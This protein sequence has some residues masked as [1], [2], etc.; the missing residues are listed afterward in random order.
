MKH[1]Q[2]AVFDRNGEQVSLFRYGGERGNDD[3]EEVA[4][5]LRITHPS[6]RVD[7]APKRLP[8]RRS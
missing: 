1:T 4:E 2:Y 7:E 3:A 8:R 5:T 6:A